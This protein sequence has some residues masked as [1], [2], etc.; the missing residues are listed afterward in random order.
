M[1]MTL[2][3]LDSVLR[4]DENF[5]M[6]KLEKF[7]RK[8]ATNKDEKEDMVQNLRNLLTLWGPGKLFSAIFSDLMSLLYLDGQINDYAARHYA[9]LTKYYSQRWEFFFLFANE[10]GCS[11]HLMNSQF[12]AEIL[13]AV[14]QKYPDFPAASTT[15]TE[16]YWGLAS[17][18]FKFYCP[19]IFVDC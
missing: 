12:P 7:A 6:G 4:G 16:N 15:V 5:M 17:E 18:I 1:G 19:K 8:S 14:E 2:F 9:D 11:Q 13:K 3:N 10:R